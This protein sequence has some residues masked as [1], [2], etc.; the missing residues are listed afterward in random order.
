MNRLK[1]EMMK[2]YVVLSVI[3]IENTK[4]PKRSYIF[5]KTSVLSIT[6]GKRGSEHENYLKKINQL[7]Y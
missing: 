4:K 6:S 7:R 2:K 3:R 1:K 5:D